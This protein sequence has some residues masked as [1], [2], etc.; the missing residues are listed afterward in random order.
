MEV[1]ALITRWNPTAARY[2]KVFHEGLVVEES[3]PL[4]TGAPIYRD[5]VG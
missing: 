3:G 4:N 5:H 1:D 2:R